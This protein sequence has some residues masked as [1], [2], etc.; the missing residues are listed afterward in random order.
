[1]KEIKDNANEKI[2]YV[3]GLEDNVKITMLTETDSI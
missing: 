3:H 1:L 2:S